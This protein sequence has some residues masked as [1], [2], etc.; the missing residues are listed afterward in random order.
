MTPP[1]MAPNRAEPPKIMTARTNKSSLFQDMKH[2]QRYLN[3]LT[4]I[5]L[6]YKQSRFR[7]Y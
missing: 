4:M 1:A 7:K 6:K 3:H 2:L 5:L